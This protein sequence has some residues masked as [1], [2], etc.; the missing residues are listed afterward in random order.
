MAIQW[1]PGHMNKARKKISEAMPGIDLVVEVL[2]ARLPW[3]STNPLVDEL[4]ADKTCIK[5]LN[6]ADLADPEV[7]R[8]WVD[9]FDS[10]MNTKAL[11]L[12]AEDRNQVKKL[13]TLCKQLGAARAEKKQAI[14]IMIM[15]IPN[16][17]KSTLINALAGRY[18]AKTGN[19][20][21]VTKSNQMIDLKNGLV[22]SD[23]PGILWPKFENENSGYRLAASGAVKDTAMEYTDVATHALGYLLQHYPDALS[24]RYKFKALPASASEA[25][26][27][28][29]A[30]RGC[31]KPGGIADLHKA[32][33][34]TLHE[35]R[36]GKIGK[37][38]LENPVLVEAEI[39]ALEEE[40]R[41]RE[42]ALKEEKD[43]Q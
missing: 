23:T 21:A 39:A 10:Q 25:L 4:R 31:L 16:V 32:A 19:E 12:V 7:T 43:G 41:L 27:T 37:I 30:K 26:E 15:G 42:E 22:L 40:R 24:A 18:I 33:E 6:K 1:F 13:I 38:S 8:Q 29:A 35:L 14:R 2:D 34:L 3:S 28:V 11:P 17:G 36:A 9:Y 20:P 5:V